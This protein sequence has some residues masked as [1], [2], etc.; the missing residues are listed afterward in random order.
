MASAVP[1]PTGSLSDLVERA[2][3]VPVPPGPLSD[4]I[5]LLLQFKTAYKAGELTSHI[6]QLWY[7]ICAIGADSHISL[8]MTPYQYDALITAPLAAALKPGSWCGKIAEAK[9]LHA[10]LFFFPALPRAMKMSDEELIKKLDHLVELFPGLWT[11]TDGNIMMRSIATAKAD[12]PG[13]HFYLVVDPTDLPR[14]QNEVLH[15]TVSCG[16]NADVRGKILTDLVAKM[17]DSKGVEKGPFPFSATLKL[18]APTQEP[19]DVMREIISQ[20]LTLAPSILGADADASVVA[21]NHAHF[22]HFATRLQVEAAAK[23]VAWT[24]KM[25]ETAKPDQVAERQAK[26]DSAKAAFET[27]VAAEVAARVAPPSGGGASSA[28]AGGAGA[29]PPKESVAELEAAVAAFSLR[30]ASASP[31]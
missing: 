4:L 23:T 6:K 12:K 1:A 19:T 30:V 26:L 9:D 20:T 7:A 11:A 27:A 29:P 3:G 25:V 22:T 15:F 13:Y 17:G 31:V 18:V 2:S 5:S 14:S 10:T 8:V 28:A 24:T 16:N 21:N